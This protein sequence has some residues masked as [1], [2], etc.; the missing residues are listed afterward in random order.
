MAALPLAAQES[1]SN[2]YTNSNMTYLTVPVYKVLES[3][4]AFIVLYGK[5]GAKIGTVCIPKEWSKPK[6]G[7]VRK[8]LIRNLPSKLNPYLCVFYQDGKFFR[9]LLTV[10]TDKRH[11]VWGT[12]PRTDIEMPSDSLE[13]QL[14]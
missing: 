13:I 11:T 7:E 10:P 4:E 14:R 8:L 12:T 6:Q 1:K 2:S 5:Y 3:P 9:A